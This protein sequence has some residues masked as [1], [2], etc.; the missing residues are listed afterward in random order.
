M[1]EFKSLGRVCRDKEMI[2]AFKGLDIYCDVAPYKET[3]VWLKNSLGK[4]E[5]SQ[6]CYI[7]ANRIQSVFHE[8]NDKSHMI[9]T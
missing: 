6:N 1:N 9:A 8:G 7:N 3:M 5:A 2:T 4:E